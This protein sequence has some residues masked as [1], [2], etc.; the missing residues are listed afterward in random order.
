MREC[1]SENKHMVF[2]WELPRKG[3]CAVLLKQTLESDT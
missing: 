1:F 2:F 3:A